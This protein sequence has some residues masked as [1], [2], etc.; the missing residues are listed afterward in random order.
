M[1]EVEEEVMGN[2]IQA[3]QWMKD[4]KDVWCPAGYLHRMVNLVV[5]IARDSEHPEKGFEPAEMFVCD[6]LAEEW[7][8]AS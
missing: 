2:I 8:L 7:K 3:A 5:C 4:G 6:L 1:E